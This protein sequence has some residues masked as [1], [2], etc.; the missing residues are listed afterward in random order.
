MQYAGRGQRHTIERG[1][2]QVPF[3]YPGSI[4]RGLRTDKEAQR[5]KERACV[6]ACV[7]A[8][9]SGKAQLSIYLP[10]ARPTRHFAEPA[11][12]K[13]LVPWFGR[14]VFGQKTR[15]LASPGTAPGKA[16][17]ARSL[18]QERTRVYV[19]RARGSEE[20]KH[21]W[22]RAVCG[23]CVCDRAV[24]GCTASHSAGFGAGRRGCV[25]RFPSKS[26][27]SRMRLAQA[28]EERDVGQQTPHAIRTRRQ[29]CVIFGISSQLKINLSPSAPLANL[30][31]RPRISSCQR[32]TG[33]VW[34]RISRDRGVWMR[35]IKLPVQ[36][37]SLQRCTCHFRQKLDR[38]FD[39]IRTF[40][41]RETSHS[42][43][44]G[45]FPITVSACVHLLRAIMHNPLIVQV[46]PRPQF[47]RPER[48]RCRSCFDGFPVPRHAERS[49]LERKTTQRKQ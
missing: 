28:Q 26:S 11:A 41:V 47:G 34:L 35:I 33:A 24:L 19:T 31:I 38:M 1:G 43:T 22:F 7:L 21:G 4:H 48:R 39:T 15:K 16:V 32:R 3:S 46:Q 17:F 44:S 8:G 14:L 20:G 2:R 36:K 29:A 23:R 37:T 18:I 9:R 30:P 12:R 49:R 25:P 5:E 40:S 10:K 45:P 6:R 27:W 42:T 13:C